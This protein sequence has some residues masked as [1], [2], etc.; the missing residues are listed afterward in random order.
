MIGVSVD[1]STTHSLPE[2]FLASIK[3]DEVL[4]YERER[5]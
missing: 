3:K 2:E 1:V 5:S 4:L